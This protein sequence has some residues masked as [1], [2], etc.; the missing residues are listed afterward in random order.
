MIFKFPI[1]Q[2]EKL[3]CGIEYMLLKLIK[4]VILF[5]IFKTTFDGIVLFAVLLRVIPLQEITQTFSQWLV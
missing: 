5:S 1:E 2:E 3:V 4:V